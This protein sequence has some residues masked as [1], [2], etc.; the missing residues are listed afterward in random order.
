MRAAGLTV[1]FY[2]EPKK[3]GQQ[4]KWAGKKGFRL[5]VV[6]GSDEFA[7]GTA[8]LK[9]LATQQ[10]TTVEWGGS[11]ERLAAAVRAAVAG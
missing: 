5:A 3:L 1:D 7:T 8:Q 6:I 9:Q 4:L 10:A 2:P 11:P